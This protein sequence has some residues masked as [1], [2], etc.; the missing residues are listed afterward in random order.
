MWGVVRIAF[1]LVAVVAALAGRAAAQPPGLESVIGRTVRAVTVS[2]AGRPLDDPSI[3]PLIDS[4]V[5]EPLDVARVRS[6]L[7]TLVALERFDDITVRAEPLDDGIAL[8]YD[9]RLTRRVTRTEFR[10]DRGFSPRRLRGVL[11]ERFGDWQTTPRRAGEMAG[12]LAEAL[13]QAGFLD[14]RVAWQLEPGAREDIATLVFDI[15]AGPQARIGAVVVEGEPLDGEARLRRRLELKPGTPWRDAATRARAEREARRWREKGRYQAHIDVFPQRRANEAVVDLRVDARPGPQIELVFEG[16]PLP[17]SRIADLVP[18]EREGAVDED[19][20]EDSKRRLERYLRSEGFWRASVE[21]QRSQSESHSRIVFDVRRG[22][23]YEVADIRLS[24]VRSLPRDTVDALLTVKPGMPFVEDEMSR[25]AQVVTRYF[26]ENGY[27]GAKVTPTVTELGESGGVTPARGRVQIQLS[28]DEGPRTLV[29]TIRIEGHQALDEA[30][31]RQVMRLRPGEPFFAPSLVADRAAVEAAYL[32]A[33]YADAKVTVAA[34]PAPGGGLA[35]VTYRVIEGERSKVEHV[36]VT[37]NER[38]SAETILREAR[39]QPGQALALQDLTGAQRRL[40]A[41]GLFRRVRVD[42]VGD[43]GSAARDVVIAVEE[44]PVTSVGYGAGI[45][46]GR[47]LR[48]EDVEGSAVERIE[49]APRGFFEVGRR[50]LWGKNRS[51]TLFSRASLRRNPGTAEDPDPGGYGIYEYRVLGTYREPRAFGWNADAT[52]SGLFEQAI[53]T[54]F[55]YRRR[56]LNADLTRRFARTVTVAARYSAGYTNVYEDRSAPEDAPLID[57]LF[58]QV[59]LS[60]VSGFATWDTQGRPHRA[61]ARALR[62]VSVGRRRSVDWIGSRLREE[63]LAGVR[64]PEARS[65]ACGVRRRRQVRTGNGLSPPG[66]GRGRGGE[67]RAR[68]ERQPGRADGEGPAVERAILRGRRYDRARL[69]A[70]SPR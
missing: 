56:A 20:L 35:D 3:R 63:L 50:N 31:L 11:S 67:P 33:G 53:R 15:T 26:Q 70:R 42:V 29:G 13:R 46:G 23:L 61:H 28:V 6:T 45:E 17:K 2:A 69:H 7:R 4:K 38:T 60:T 37:G 40:A 68:R 14:A 58:P 64:L 41:L 9:V 12:V 36:V 19:L 21:Y 44:A 32:G 66:A 10:G 30:T 8:V 39:I 25:D 52:V 18:V 16:D 55:S 22:L 34:E 43:A 27:T 65:V 5:G 62:G 57:R 49:F 59:R 1:V 48:R 54:S 47:L 24:G 51:L